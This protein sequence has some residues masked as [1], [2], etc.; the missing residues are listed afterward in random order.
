MAQWVNDL[1][2]LCCSAVLI[3]GGAQWVKDLALPQLPCRLQLRLRFDPWPENFH[4][5][6]VSL[7]KKGKKKMAGGRLSPTELIV[8]KNK[9]QKER[10][11]GHYGTP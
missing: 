9:E 1:A 6:W 5:P 10:E 7:K 3:S 11:K 4:I 8:V 2:C